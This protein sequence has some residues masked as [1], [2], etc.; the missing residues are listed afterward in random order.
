MTFRMFF[1]W[2]KT[3]MIAIIALAG[4]A[5]AVLDAVMLSGATPAFE[6]TNVPVAAVSLAAAVLIDVFALLLL[7]NSRYKLKE[8]C[9]FSVMG[10]F[11]DRVAY[12]D[13]YRI[14]VNAATGE[15]FV[16]WRKGGVGADNV[17]RLNLTEKDAKAILPELERRCGSAV[18]ETFTPPEKKKKDK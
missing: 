3:A 11:V 17:A 2:I 5:I 10:M 6:T 18:T 7:F 9:I 15:V 16:A 13:V 1:G 12:E 8:D 4:A 14:S